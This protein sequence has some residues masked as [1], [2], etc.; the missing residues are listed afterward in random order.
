MDRRVPSREELFVMVWERPATEVARELGLSDVGLGKLCERLQVPKPPRGYWARVQAGR[1]PKQPPLEAFRAELAGRPPTRPG[2]TRLS[3]RRRAW[4]GEALADL[5]AAGVDTAGCDLVH[6]GFRSITPDLAAQVIVRVQ[7][8][9]AEWTGEDDPPGARQAAQQSAAGLIDTLLPLAKEQVVVLRRHVPEPKDA[10]RHTDDR[11]AVILR[12]SADLQRDVV[13][14]HQLA[15]D[16]GLAY[17][18]R[19]LTREEHAVAARYLR[20]PAESL[21][22]DVVLCVSDKELWV[23]GRADNWRHGEW[24]ETARL[25]VGRIVPVD[26]LPPSDKRLPRAVGRT[27]LRPYARRL[28]ALRDADQVVDLVSGLTFAQ[29]NCLDDAQAA[30]ADRLLV[31][32]L[33][34]GPFTE[35]R[36]RLRRLEAQVEQ[37]EEA[38]A[39]EK[40]A[41]CR[42][43][44]GIGPGDTVVFESGGK[45]A[46][47]DVTDATVYVSDDDVLFHISG[48]RYRKDGLP[49]KRDEVFT[50]GVENDAVPKRTGNT[51][52][53]GP[54][55]TAGG[56]AQY[57][58]W[59]HR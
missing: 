41:F 4:L 53:T 42:E 7:S 30:L 26:L 33:G 18:A 25:P 36:R 54:E 56:P 50:L 37:W 16:A 24:F 15:R 49:G 17:A 31:G 46:R 43:V 52:R 8:R 48:R 14:M 12:L 58:F 29:D 10:Y 2:V 55:P 32:G 35:V 38:I 23:A 6:D 19:S 11:L 40:A 57:P 51:L 21:G 28:K 34:E 44:L 59:L 45:P 5:A 20:A 22:A 9:Y 13:R 47:M 1:T 27:W 39:G 3:R